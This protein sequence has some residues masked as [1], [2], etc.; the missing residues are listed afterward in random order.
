MSEMTSYE[1]VKTALNYEEPDRVP[2]ALG[3]G[4]YGVVDELYFKLLEQ[5]EL[6]E[7]S[8]P[9]RSGHNISYID[10]R[11]MERLGIDTRYVWPGDSPSSAQY[12]TGEADV[13]LDGYGQPW[14]Q[15][16]PYYFPMEGI[17][18][19]A[20][21]D[22][23]DQIVRW[24][25][26]AAP[27]WT[28]GVRERAQ[29]L[30]E[31]ADCYVIA[32]MVT[33][34]GPYMTAAHLR[35]TQQFLMDMALNPSFVET[36][37]DKVTGSIDNLL[38]SYLRAAG[39]YIDMI[40]L[41]GDDY[42]T[43]KSLIMSPQMF[44][45]FFKPALS[46]LVNSIKSY[47][48][49][50]KVMLHSDGFIKPLLEDF[51]DIGVDVVHPLEPLEMVDQQAVKEAFAGRLAFLGGIDIVHALPGGKEEVVAEVKRRIR[52]L[53]PGGGYVLAP[54]NH[55]QPDVPPDNVVALFEAAREYGRYPVR[56]PEWE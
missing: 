4:P 53:A 48:D 32:R 44:R 34:H 54:S 38:R 18:A 46:R 8:A 40:E 5:L 19:N 26:P 6:G 2:V 55:L 17:L 49:G 11:M 37:V 14:R 27:E 29:R 33:S 31:G 25:D 21:I 47:R 41:P 3:G 22:E 16:F 1:R 36:L 45:Q 51:V 28:A 24:P 10:D 20:G 7:P 13:Y 43:A 30:K 35:G 56:P 52:Q 39:P 50:L 42:A 15:A 23:I 9:F 12:P